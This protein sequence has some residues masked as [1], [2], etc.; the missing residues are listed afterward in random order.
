MID[1]DTEQLSANYFKVEE[2]VAGTYQE[3]QV[4]ADKTFAPYGKVNSDGSRTNGKAKVRIRRRRARDEKRESFRIVLFH[5][6]STRKAEKP[7]EVDNT[8]DAK[9][10]RHRND[11]K[12]QKQK[13]RGRKTTS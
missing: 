5:H 9:R 1:I 8:N 6:V 12:G 3:A 11:R 13:V 7:V 4:I 10:P 2:H